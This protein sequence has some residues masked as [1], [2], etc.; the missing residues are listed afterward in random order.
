M[1]NYRSICKMEIAANRSGLSMRDVARMLVL[2]YDEDFIDKYVLGRKPVDINV[3]K[4][5]AD[6]F[7][8]N[9]DYL[10]GKGEP[11]TFQD[12][13]VEYVVAS[14]HKADYEEEKHLRRE[15]S[16]KMG[17]RIRCI[18]KYRGISRMEVEQRV[19]FLPVIWQMVEEGKIPLGLEKLAPLAHLL[20]VSVDCLL[21]LEDFTVDYND[22]HNVKE[23]IA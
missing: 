6:R 16:E 15:F 14:H 1:R 9:L 3:M 12:M 4:V 21:G 13:Y 11:R 10:L 2:D 8:L 5:F 20:D 17:Q 7:K 19:G 22:N 18:R 23:M